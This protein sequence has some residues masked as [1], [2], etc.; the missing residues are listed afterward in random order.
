MRPASMREKS[1]SVFTS[2]SRRS[3]LRWA[4]SIAVAASAGRPAS[5][6]SSRSC[7]GPIISVSGVRNSCETFEKN[8]VFARSSSASASARRRSSSSACASA[9]AERDLRRDQPEERAVVLVQCHAS[10]SPPR[11]RS[12]ADAPARQQHRQ[13]QRLCG[14]RFHAPVGKRVEPRGQIRE[15]GDLA[16]LRHGSAA[17]RDR[18]QRRAA[19][20]DSGDAAVPRCDAGDG[21]QRGRRLRP[22]RCGRSSRTACRAGSRARIV[23]AACVDRVARSRRPCTT[24]ARS[25]SV[26]R[27]RSPMTFSVVS[28]TGQKTPPT[29]PSSP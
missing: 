11:R 12:R 21:L 5:P 10:G 1:S 22:R 15:H 29:L 13:H 9:S 19:R 18:R 28:M 2:L 20:T 3:P 27:R 24:A 4:T 7:S 23:A 14:G 8:V 17:T 6:L 25:R 16:R 26:R